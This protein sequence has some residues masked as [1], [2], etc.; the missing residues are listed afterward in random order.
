MSMSC[1]MY[2]RDK[3]GC[4]NFINKKEPQSEDVISETAST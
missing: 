4:R 1:G 2:E 3:K